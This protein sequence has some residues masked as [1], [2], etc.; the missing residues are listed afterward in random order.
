MSAEWRAQ[1]ERGNP[2]LLR[3]MGRIGLLLGRRRARLLLYPICAYY[4]LFWPRALRRSRS[5]LGRVLGRQP[6]LRDVFRHY[7]TFAST[8]LDRV[9]FVTGRMT[10]L[11]VETHGAGLLDRLLAGGRGCLLLSAHLG[12]FEA[13]RATGVQHRAP[14][15]NMLMRTDDTQRIARIL[16]DWA[17]ELAHRIIRLGSP[18]SLLRAKEC[19]E[20]GQV[21]GILADRLYDDDRRFALLPFLGEPARFPLAPFRLATMLRV[22]VV[23][24]FGLY[25]GGSR[26]DIVLEVLAPDGISRKGG[27]SE[28]VSWAERFVCRLEHYCREA[29]Y[30]W[31]NFYD[32]WKA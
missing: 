30:N 23:L 6:N 14:P 12:S 26:Y 21:V 25:R 3:V 16:Q 8:V 13:L 17:P 10:D 18:H 5:Y 31:F 7:H 19:L 22:P 20:R 32:Y 29:P 15:I 1:R 2:L 9:Y 28:L 24:G 4:L 11:H 27:E